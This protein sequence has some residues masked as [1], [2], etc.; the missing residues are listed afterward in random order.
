MLTVTGSA[1]LQVGPV[2]VGDGR[3]QPLHDDDRL[4]LGGRGQDDEELVAGP[5]VDLV[6]GAAVLAEQVGDPAQH[7]VAVGVRGAV[8]DL[9]EPVDVD[10]GERQRLHAQAH[11]AQP[12]L[13]AAPVAEPGERVLQ[14]V[15]AQ[16]HGLALGLAQ[17]A[18]AHEHVGPHL[19]AAGVRAAGVGAVG[20]QPVQRLGRTAQVGGVLAQLEQALPVAAAVAR[21]GEGARGVDEQADGLLA[22]VGASSRSASRAS[23]RASA[24]PV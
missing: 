13:G 12:A 18:A 2:G 20:L 3:A 16:Q 11:R 5:A 4:R 8:V 15:P 7:G 9:L 24:R 21:G 19:A 17:P 1:H 10:D 23:S 22:A 14:R 6:A